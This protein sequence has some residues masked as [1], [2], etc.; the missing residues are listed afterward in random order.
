MVIFI[1]LGLL[2]LCFLIVIIFF[3]MDKGI[4]II[5][6]KIFN[7]GFFGD[8]E[9]LL[10]VWRILFLLIVLL[11]RTRVIIFSCSYI[12]GLFVRN[13]IFLYLSFIISILWLI[14]NN[15]FYW[16][17]FGWDGLG[18]VSFLLIIFYINHESINNGL[19][20]LFQNRLGDLFFVLFILG[21]IDL[22]LWNNLI[23][24]WG[25]LFLIFGSCVKSAQFPFNSWLLSAIRAP[26]PISSL[27]HSSTLVVA[28]VFILLQYRYCLIDMLYILKYVSLLRLLVRRFGLIN[29]FDMKKLI[30]YS[31]ISHVSLILYILSFK[32][33]KVVYFHLNIHAIFK[34]LIFMC[35]GFVILS[36]FHSQDKRLIILLY[37][38][39]LIK[40]LYYFSCICLAGLPFLRGFFSKDF[41]IEKIIEFNSEI[42]Y[43]CLLLL[44][45]RLRVYY[46]LK[47][48]RLTEVLFSFT[49]IE[50]RFLGLWRVIFMFF[51]MIFVI[52]IYIRLMF[53]LSLEYFSYKI[54]VYLL[55]LIFIFT[56]IRSN[57]NYKVFSYDKSK[58]FIE[59]WFLDY[60]YL[61]KYL[62]WNIF[63]LVTSVNHLRNIKLFLLINWWVL[64]LVVVLFC[65]KSLF[66]C[67]F[68]EVKS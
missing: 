8:Y 56:S 20:T 37:I 23:L 58:N 22:T 24:K 61:D 42:I 43:V 31:T 29:E 26:T 63:L 54:S 21:I 49:I 57:F 59:I 27:V 12:S 66:K 1:T 50:K 52:N 44:F 4:L 25:L 19:F 35:F 64:I 55:V 3:L 46:S 15:N 53:R 2:I 13:F 65:N 10:N 41:I 33:Y 36:S 18:V 60:Y 7:V 32:L 14:L 28:G 17:M 67:N 5:S 6:I 47:L 39:P 62:Y 16:M 34:S 9:L 38:N 11:I 45:L 68:E 40:I 51:L 48:L 30:A